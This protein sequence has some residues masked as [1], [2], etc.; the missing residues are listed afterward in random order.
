MNDGASVFR[1]NHGFDSSFL[2]HGLFDPVLAA[3]FVLLLESPRASAAEIRREFDF[4]CHAA[5]IKPDCKTVNGTKGV[6]RLL[7]R[8]GPFV[9][10]QPPPLSATCPTRG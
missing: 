7:R 1:H 3:I 4:R 6:V 10:S 9:R 2:F 5:E 8:S